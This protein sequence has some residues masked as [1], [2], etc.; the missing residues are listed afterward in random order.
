MAQYRKTPRA[1][2]INYDYGDYFITL[3]TQ[4]RKHYF[5]EI[6]NLEMVLNEMGLFA[7]EQLSRSTEICSYAKVLLFVV[8]PNH[9]HFIVSI[10]EYLNSNDYEQR[11]LNPSLRGN[12]TCQRHVPT[13]SK[14]I[15]S[16]KGAVTKYAKSLNIEFS[17]QAR[18]HDHLIRG[19]KD[20]NNISEYILNN[21][22][23]WQQDCLND[24][25]V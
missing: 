24:D 21:V 16:F 2:F 18:Y 12:P 4:N 10:K 20:G 25:K 14:F 3:C 5:G 13:L 8:M 22:V 17:W 15:S 11:S 7:Y 19:V 9:I 23:R 6:I 1:R